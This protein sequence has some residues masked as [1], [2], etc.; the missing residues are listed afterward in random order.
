MTL[1]RSKGL[2]VE[3][4]YII[5]CNGGNIPGENKSVYLTSDE[6]KQEQRR[7]LFVGLTRAKKTVTITWS[8]YIPFAE[9]RRNNTAS[10]GT[11]T[12]NGKPMSKVSLS[13]FLEGVNFNY[14]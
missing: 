14:V 5:G 12:K 2:D 13:E 8:R 6:H 9:S 10:I 11:I 4:V 3:H 7:L 1:L